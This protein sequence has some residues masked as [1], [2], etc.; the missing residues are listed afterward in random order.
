MTRRWNTSKSR[1]THD[2]L[3]LDPSEWYLYHTLYREA[4]QR[5]P[6]QP[7]E[8]IAE[9]VRALM[10]LKPGRSRGVIFDNAWL[11]KKKYGL[12]NRE[13]FKRARA[14]AKQRPTPSAKTSTKTQ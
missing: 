7:Y 12:D 9:Q 6:E 2:W 1:T 4:R 11:L 5:W 3:Q 13:A 10:Q 14:H 8:R